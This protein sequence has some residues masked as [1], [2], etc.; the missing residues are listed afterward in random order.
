MA[1]RNRPAKTTA[2]GTTKFLVDELNPTGYA[3]VMDLAVEI[4]RRVPKHLV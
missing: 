4:S 2:N 1:N 3:Q